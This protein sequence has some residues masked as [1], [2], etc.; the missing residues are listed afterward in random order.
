MK[1]RTTILALLLT[2]T[3]AWG[4]IPKA[5]T[6]TQVDIVGDVVA[7]GHPLA[8]VV[9]TC[10]QSGTGACGTLYVEGIVTGDVN[11]GIAL[12]GVAYLKVGQVQELRGTLAGAWVADGRAELA[13]GLRAAVG[14]FPAGEVGVGAGVA[15]QPT[16]DGSRVQLPV[17]VLIGD[18]TASEGGPEFAV[19]AE[20]PDDTSYFAGSLVVDGKLVVDGADLLAEL[21][22]LRREVA[23]LRATVE[24][25]R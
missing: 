16:G 7:D 19:F 20:G 21:R 4:Q 17:G 1:I 24:A 8:R 22:T 13:V 15:I 2:A 12:S 10:V 6:A 5:P 14:T 3:P 9:S 25:L 23:R 11:L 18:Q